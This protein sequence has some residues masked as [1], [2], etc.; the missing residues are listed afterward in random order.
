VIL[1]G[2]ALGFLA[3]QLGAAYLVGFAIGD[4]VIGQPKWVFNSVSGNGVFDDGVLA[5]VV[6]LRL[7]MLIGYLLFAALIVVMP[8]VLRRLID[9]LPVV[10]RLPL[11]LAVSLSALL[12]VA[13]VY[14][15]VHLWAAATPVLIRPLYTWSANI[16]LF[17]EVRP[18]ALTIPL[19]AIQTLQRDRIWIV[20][21]AIIATLVR[22]GLLW[23]V[24]QC[25]PLTERLN[26]VEAALAEPPTGPPARPAVAR[27]GKIKKALA[28]AVL[29]TFVFSG[30][31]ASWWVA[32]LFF[33]Q[34]LLL[35]LL[36]AGIISLPIDPWRRLMSRI[37][38]LFRLTLALFVTRA[39]GAALL[40]KKSESFTPLALY[41]AGVLCILVTL[42]PGQPA[43]QS[44][45]KATT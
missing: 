40:D 16:L 21:A 12:N 3:T 32:M 31:I 30:M 33:I 41:V 27:M 37:P 9:G 28:G 45:V 7:P 4:F 43:T 10:N 23:L 1:I 42:M 13:V 34:L 8:M 29:T 22:Y 36:T 39:I 14:A 44:S 5:A 11:W 20:R 38:L 25:R 17:G 24:W 26:D 35:R 15:G 18:P 19:D 2:V 6:R